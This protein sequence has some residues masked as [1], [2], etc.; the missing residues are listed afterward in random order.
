MLLC[1]ISSFLYDLLTYFI[2]YLTKYLFL[3]TGCEDRE[4]NFAEVFLFFFC[5]KKFVIWGQN[6]FLQIRLKI[7]GQPGLLFWI[8]WQVLE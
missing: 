4:Y 7:K 8:F 1:L 6:K 5:G 3:R 2:I